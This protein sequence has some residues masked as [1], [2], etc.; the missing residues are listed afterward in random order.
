VDG[1][2]SVSLGRNVWATAGLGYVR[3]RRV[4]QSGNLPRIPPLNGRIAIDIPFR[5]VTL[6]PE[7]M[8]AASQDNLADNETRTGGYSVFNLNA[9]YIFA[10]SHHA[11]VFSV[12]GLNLTDELYRRHT[13]F[14]K[15][16]AP[17]TGRSVRVSYAIRFF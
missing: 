11:H 15:D 16:L 17:E 7:L 9:S 8:W 14:I 6:A 3:A 5:G 13:S 2:A 10:R 12:S 4:N 1:Q